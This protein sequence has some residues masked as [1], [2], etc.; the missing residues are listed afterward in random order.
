M[1]V[2]G[3]GIPIRESNTGSVRIVTPKKLSRT[4]EWPSHAALRRS[5]G[6]SSGRGLAKDGAIGSWLST[7]HSRQRWAIQPRG[8]L[9]ELLADM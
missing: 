1:A 5:L 6:H 7:V 8:R 4:V 3:S 9:R 2:K